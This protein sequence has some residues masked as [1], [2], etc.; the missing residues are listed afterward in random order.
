[1]QSFVETCVDFDAAHLRINQLGLE[2]TI[3]IQIDRYTRKH[4]NLIFL[5]W[6]TQ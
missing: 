1:M 6:V 2:I 3:V 5:H 4:P